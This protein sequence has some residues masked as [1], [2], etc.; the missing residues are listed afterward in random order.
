[1]A[2]MLALRVAG[3]IERHGGSALQFFS[4]IGCFAAVEVLLNALASKSYGVSPAPDDKHNF[5]T[6][7]SARCVSVPSCCSVSRTRC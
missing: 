3:M 1:M 7:D 4:I 6:V 5:Q 2:N